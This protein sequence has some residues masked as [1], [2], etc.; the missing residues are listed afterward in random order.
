MHPLQDKLLNVAAERN[1]GR[2]SYRVIGKL[3]G[4]E[5]PQK[6]KEFLIIPDQ[7][8]LARRPSTIALS[9]VYVLALVVLAVMRHL[10]ETGRLM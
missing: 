6:V 10:P 3:I 9:H 2:L 1:L 4:E 7:H 8:T 5:H